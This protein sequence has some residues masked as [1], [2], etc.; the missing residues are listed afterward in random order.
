MATTAKESRHHV[1][2]DYDEK[3]AVGE[4]GEP[5]QKKKIS[6]AI[7][8]DAPRTV[9]HFSSPSYLSRLSTLQL[10]IMVQS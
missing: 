2:E 4:V 10:H 8:S 7:E 9:R 1:E 5:Q 6:L 3:V